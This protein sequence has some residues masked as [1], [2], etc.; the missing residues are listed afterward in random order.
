MPKGKA[1]ARRATG[2][3]AGPEDKSAPE[4]RTEA[5]ITVKNGPE[6]LQEPDT[7]NVTRKE[8]AQPIE[9]AEALLHHALKDFQTIHDETLLQNEKR[10]TLDLA[11]FIEIA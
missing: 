5:E 6:Q 3:S 2:K 7:T 11:W 1:P 4:E 10:V 9:R 8:K